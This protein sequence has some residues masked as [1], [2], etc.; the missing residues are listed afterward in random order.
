MAYSTTRCAWRFP[1]KLTLCSYHM[2]SSCST[3]H[4]WRSRRVRFTSGTPS[5]CAAIMPTRQAA[6]ANFE[7]ASFARLRTLHPCGSW[8]P[9]R[10]GHGMSSPGQT[11]PFSRA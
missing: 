4:G 10:Y 8:M 3:W 6:R 2:S 7:G 11:P 9:A 1:G 5:I